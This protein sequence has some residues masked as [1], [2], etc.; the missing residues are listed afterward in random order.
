MNSSRGFI[1]IGMTTTETPPWFGRVSYRAPNIGNG[2]VRH[3]A[4]SL[5][6][7]ERAMWGLCWECPTLVTA[8]RPWLEIAALAMG[9]FGDRIN[10]ATNI[11]LVLA[12]TALLPAKAETC[13]ICTRRRFPR[14]AR[15]G[16]SLHRRRRRP[17]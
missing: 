15:S 4:C 14:E 17:V 10:P 6:I 1:R 13:Q 11:R 2:K 16:E 7:S 12:E 8:R 9:E 5:P 3:Q